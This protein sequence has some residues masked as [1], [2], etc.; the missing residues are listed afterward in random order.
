[1]KFNNS[2]MKRSKFLI[3]FPH[4]LLEIAKQLKSEKLHLIH[5]SKIWKKRIKSLVVPK[6]SK[7]TI[8]GWENKGRINNE[9][10]EKGE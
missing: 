9:N 2:K 6:R 1:M 3:N 8:K 4:P 5:S 7:I 10:E